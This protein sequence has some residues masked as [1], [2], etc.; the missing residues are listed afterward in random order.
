MNSLSVS[1]YW[2][3]T[4]DWFLYRSINKIVVYF[5]LHTELD[6]SLWVYIGFYPSQECIYNIYSFK[7]VIPNNLTYF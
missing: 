1:C 7:Y 3:L 6:R 2:M 5:A 4:D